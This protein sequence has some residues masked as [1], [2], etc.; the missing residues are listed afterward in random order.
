MYT[1]GNCI[2]QAIIY[3][4]CKEF[5][6]ILIDFLSENYIDFDFDFDFKDLL[7]NYSFGLH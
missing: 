7:K 3:K 6:H 4:L 5:I 1:L 2:A